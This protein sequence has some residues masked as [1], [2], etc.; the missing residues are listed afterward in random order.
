M[1]YWIIYKADYQIERGVGNLR[2]RPGYA[3]H[4]A[5]L[6]VYADGS[7]SEPH[8]RTEWCEMERRE[9]ASPL[10]RLSLASAMETFRSVN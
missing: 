7:T 4:N 5:W 8:T 3:W 10:F 2:R 1:D 9:G 6:R